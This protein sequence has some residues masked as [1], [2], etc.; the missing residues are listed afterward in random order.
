MQTTF[1]VIA[2][3]KGGV[4]KTSTAINLSAA[5]QEF[6]RNVVIVDGNYSKP[7]VGVMLGITK[8]KNTLHDTLRSHEHITNSVYIHPSGLQVIPGSILYEEIYSE[9]IKK[10]E[11]AIMPL[12]G[13]TEL[14][15]VDSGPGFS[16][17]TTEVIDLADKLILITTPDLASITDTLKTKKFCK[18]RGIEILGVVV[19]H[20]K[21]NEINMNLK[22]I[23][24]IIEEKVIG[25]IPFDES[26]PESQHNKYPVLDYA[27]NSLASVAY[28][29]LAANLIGEEYVADKK[30]NLYDYI[31]KKLGFR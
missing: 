2:S 20:V 18:D 21:K 26:I 27:E 16:T 19:T 28:K 17:E 10:I 23:E 30:I 31:L 13:K 5:L 29:K 6:G 25:E 9:H 12:R 1:I 15:I 24:L 22:D 8:L 3:A 4:G 14:V 11:E 7:N